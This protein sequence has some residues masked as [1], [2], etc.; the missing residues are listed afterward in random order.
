FCVSG[1]GLRQVSGL[2]GQPAAGDLEQPVGQLRVADAA[3]L[4]Q[5]AG[6][7]GEHSRLC[8]AASSPPPRAASISASRLLTTRRWSGLAV[9]T[10]F[11][12]PLRAWRPPPAAVCRGGEGV[13]RHP[14][15]FTVGPFPSADDGEEERTVCNVCNR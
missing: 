6:H 14:F 4:Q 3:R 15:S 5:G 2:G 10:A 7:R 1:L 12:P 8:V 11:H 13:L 9:R